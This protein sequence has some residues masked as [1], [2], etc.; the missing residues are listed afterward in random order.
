LWA[1]ERKARVG[2][3]VLD[4]GRVAVMKLSKTD[5]VMAFGKKAFAKV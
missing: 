1:Q 5:D 3:Q 4:V 2:L